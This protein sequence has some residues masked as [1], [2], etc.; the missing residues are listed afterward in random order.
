[1]QLGKRNNSYS[2]I[3]IFEELHY[4]IT[5]NSRYIPNIDLSNGSP[6]RL[7]R[8]H[9]IRISIVPSTTWK[10]NVADTRLFFLLSDIVIK[11]SCQML[12]TNN[13]QLLFIYVRSKQSL[14]LGSFG[15][16]SVLFGVIRLSQRSYIGR[17][18]EIFW[19]SVWSIGLHS[20]I[21]GYTMCF[22][23]FFVRLRLSSA[24][25]L[26]NSMHPSIQFNSNGNSSMDSLLV[27]MFNIDPYLL[28][29]YLSEMCSLNVNSILKFHTQWSPL[30]S[31][32]GITVL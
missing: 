21:F 17:L 2:V 23:L 13:E 27:L 11:W 1:M 7:M 4:L 15:V 3:F 9:C 6:D 12:D 31:K 19:L 14:I 18:K 16:F 25:F 8:I 22:Q 5:C 32:L 26:I 10:H 28:S 20:G 29:L 30:A 24:V